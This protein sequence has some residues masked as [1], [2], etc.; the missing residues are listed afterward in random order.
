MIKFGSVSLLAAALFAGGLSTPALANTSDIV[1]LIERPDGTL[2]IEEAPQTFSLTKV[3]SGDKVLGQQTE[4]VA[5]FP[6]QID[7]QEHDDEQVTEPSFSLWTNDAWVNDMRRWDQWNLDYVKAEDAW[8]I[9]QGEGVTVAVLDSG[10]YAEHPDFEGRVVRGYVA[11]GSTPGDQDGHGTHV[12]GIIAAGT[13]NKIDIAGLAPKVTIWDGKITADNAH[14]TSTMMASGIVAAVNAN[15]DIINISMTAKTEMP[16]V[17]SAIKAANDRGIPVVV[18]AG[19]D[20]ASGSPKRWPAAYDD[21]FTVG[22]IKEDGNWASFS[23]TNDYIDVTAPGYYIAGLNHQGG[24][25]YMH[26]TSQ[27]APMVSGTLALLKAANPSLS[28][29]TLQDTVRNT[30][31]GPRKTINVLSALTRVAPQPTPVA[32]VAPEMPVNQTPSSPTPQAPPVTAPLPAPVPAPH[33]PAPAPHAPQP[34]PVYPMP[35]PAPVQ[36]APAQPAPKQPA[37]VELAP[38]PN[39]PTPILH[40]PNAPKPMNPVRH[41]TRPER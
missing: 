30:A 3:F 19:N 37:P 36:P 33:V 34:S 20:A 8:K 22:A 9:S 12:A 18:S 31:T 14:G 23:N 24:F 26:G 21:C 41:F 2:A 17:E 6:D 1:R 15:V 38:A 11:P 4:E 10:V 32:P 39:V 27:A 25:M 28:Y 7:L 29:T 35:Q 16:L 5:T 40:K 13:N